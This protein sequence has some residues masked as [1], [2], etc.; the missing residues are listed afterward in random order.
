MNNGALPNLVIGVVV[1][2]FAVAFFRNLSRKP[3]PEKKRRE[4]LAALAKKL[5]L[6]FNPGNDFKLAEKFSFLNWLRRGE[7]RYAW[8]VLHGNYLEHLMTCFDYHFSTPT[9]GKSGGYD[10]YW[11]A[12]I[13]EMHTNFPD[14]IISHESRESRLVEALGESHIAFE[15]AEFSHAFRVRSLDKKFAYDVCHP[16]MMEY[17]LANQDLTV[18]ISCTGLAVFFEDWLR[19]EKIEFNLS[20]L[21]EI[22][23]LLPEYLFTNS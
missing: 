13:V 14:M 12:F 1:A 21:V 18:E 17:L 5:K 9:G 10:Y 6:R 15:S 20:R 11:S 16:K 4:D 7:V 8:N 3:D 23:K 22:R 19:P 2:I